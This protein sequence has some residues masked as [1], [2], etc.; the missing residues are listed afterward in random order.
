MTKPQKLETILAKVKDGR[1]LTAA[2]ERFV[3]QSKAESRYLPT[4]DAVAAH[5]GIARQSLD[6]WRA[7]DDELA[8][9][10]GPNGYDLDAIGRVRRKFVA[11]GKNP[12]LLAG[13][14]DG[15]GSGDE[16]DVALLK[17]RKIRLECDKLATQIDILRAKYA[18]VDDIMAQLMPI[19][20]RFKEKVDRLGPELAFQVSGSSPADAE[21]I[22]RDAGDKLLMELSDDDIP[23]MEAA[24]RK[25]TDNLGEQDGRMPAARE[26]YGRAKA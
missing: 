8:L 24:L 18:L 14:L 26:A 21:Q 19:I 10:K 6:K 16:T 25:P 7:K 9:E 11:E 22:I 13:D 2:E 20:Y 17:A 5:Y 1:K 3:E 23:R 4:L 15:S 12:R